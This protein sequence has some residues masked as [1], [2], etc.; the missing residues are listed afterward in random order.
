MTGAFA[1]QRSVQLQPSHPTQNQNK[2]YSRFSS[3]DYPDLDIR[4]VGFAFCV[5]E[6]E[7]GKGVG[8]RSREFGKLTFVAD[9]VGGVS[10]DGGKWGGESAGG[11]RAEGCGRSER[12][13]LVLRERG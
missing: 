10:E 7:G 8:R 3:R 6:A 9:G 12:D 4:A 13:E 5:L 1:T 11:W 2:Q